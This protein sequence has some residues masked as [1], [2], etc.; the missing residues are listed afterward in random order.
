MKRN[1]L[2]FVIIAAVGIFSAII[3]FYVGVN[4][5]EDI[6][7]A[8][9]NEEQTEENGN[10]END[11]NEGETDDPEAIFESN[12]A[13]CH[14]DDLEGGMGPDLTEVGGELSEDEIHDTIMNGKGD[15]PAG[16]VEEDEADALTEWLADMD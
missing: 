3:V 6:Q 10:D 15:M 16:L 5:R 2:P 4:Q 1:V 11:E 12:C 14:G 9:E 13:S 7:Q 8:D